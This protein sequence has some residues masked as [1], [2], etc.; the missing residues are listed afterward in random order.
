MKVEEI[1]NIQREFSGMTRKKAI[2]S[3]NCRKCWERFF[4]IKGVIMSEWVPMSQT[5][6]QKYYRGKGGKE[7][8]KKDQLMNF[9]TEQRATPQCTVCEVF[10][11]QVN[12]CARAS[13]IFARSQL[14]AT[15]VCSQNWKLHWR[16]NIFNLWRDKKGQ[17]WQMIS[18]NISLN[19]WRHVN[20]WVLKWAK[21]NNKSIHNITIVLCYPTHQRT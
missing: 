13:L 14:Y 9:I 18:Y 4:D 15:S 8:G 10:F 20:K 1:I 7:L 5:V 19:K 6:Y 12:S 11:E 17:V 2:E 3:Q 21:T 16:K